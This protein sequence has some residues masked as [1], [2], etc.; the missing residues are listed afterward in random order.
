MNSSIARRTLNKARFCVDQAERCGPDDQTA[1]ETYI[2]AAIV[3]GRSVT[4]HIKAEYIHRPGFDSW[5]SAHVNA[6]RSDPLFD[7]FLNARNFVLKRGPVK[8]HKVIAITVS[9]GT[10]AYAIT[11]GVAQLI[12][13]PRRYLRSPKII[14]QDLSTAMMRTIRKWRK[15]RKPARR[16]VHTQEQQ[17]GKVTESFYFNDSRV[18]DRPAP[19]VFR[20]YLDKLEE[21]VNA[22][23]EQFGVP[24]EEERR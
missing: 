21:I 14:W 19:E 17:S 10:G 18:K 8:F 2:E 3:F 11:G 16:R 15:R 12:R 22:A 5:Y 13:S 4:L 20:D 7:F 9:V 1:F 24:D 6:M 23:E